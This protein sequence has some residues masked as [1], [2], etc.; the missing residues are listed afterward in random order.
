MHQ[1]EG[2]I[3]VWLNNGRIQ[4]EAKKTAALVDVNLF[5][6]FG[7]VDVMPA[8]AEQQT[9]RVK[10]RFKAYSFNVSR[11]HEILDELI[12]AGLIKASFGSFPT[13][14]QMRGKKYFKFH[15]VWTYNTA[16]CV[17]LKDQIQEWVNEGRIQFEIAANTTVAMVE[18]NHD[19]KNIRKL[20]LELL[21]SRPEEE[22]P[23]PKRLKPAQ[24]PQL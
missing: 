22:E 8:R 3:Q 9:R 11:A 18:L 2:P 19:K 15:N 17:K 21:T 20:T 5:P 6:Y 10:P 13:I 23:A 7:M 24:R 14:E 16:S 1:V 12:A 4:V